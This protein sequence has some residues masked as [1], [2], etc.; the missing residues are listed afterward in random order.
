MRVVPADVLAH[1]DELALGREQ[2]GG[3]QAAR[4]LERALRGAQ[5]L[6]QLA[7]HAA[8][9]RPDPR[10]SGAASDLHLVDRRLAADAAARRRVEVPL[11]ERRRRTAAAG[12]TVTML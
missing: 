2:A 6:G 9:D 12:A 5:P 3:V 8:C 4:P 10:G 11:D 1:R 7:D